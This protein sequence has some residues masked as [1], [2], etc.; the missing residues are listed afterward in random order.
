M[1][2]RCVIWF[3]LALILPIAPARA[4]ISGP[5]SS[6]AVF[7]DSL[8]DTGNIYQRTNGLVLNLPGGPVTVERR[9]EVPFYTRARF[10]NGLDNSGLTSGPVISAPT[11]YQGV[12]HENLAVSLGLPAATPSLLGGR[13]FAFGAATT[14]SGSDPLGLIVNMSNQVQQYVAANPT[15]PADRLHVVFGGGNDLINVA[16]TPGGAPGEVTVAGQ[17]ALANLRSHIVTLYNKGARKFLW[18]NLPPVE[19]TPRLQFL[20]TSSDPNDQAVFAA[21]AAATAAFRIDQQATVMN[22]MSALPGAQIATVDLHALFQ[23][24]DANPTAFG[25]TNTTDPFVRVEQGITVTGVQ[26]PSAIGVSPDRFVFW[27]EI[28]PTSFVHNLI[29]GRALAAIPEPSAWLWVVSLSCL[30]CRRRAA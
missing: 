23:A 22:L 6:V 14:G 7:G 20:A 3:C 2:A 11:L 28:H 10:T 29:A 24:V 4:A 21:T 15:L 13:N 18:P 30:A 17:T 27:D 5:I 9:P 16:S 25:L 19:R 1:L 26:T 8:S 12:W